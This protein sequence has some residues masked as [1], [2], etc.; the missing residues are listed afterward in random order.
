MA[1]TKGN[2][3][4]TTTT[5]MKKKT[6]EKVFLLAASAASATQRRVQGKAQR[7]DRL[8]RAVGRSVGQLR[9]DPGAEDGGG[10]VNSGSGHLHSPL[11]RRAA[12]AAIMGGVGRSR[13]RRAR[14]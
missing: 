9:V 14:C 3:A 1:T 4:A 6:K 10:P 5:T 12:A 7:V 8:G 13:G 2:S 11:G